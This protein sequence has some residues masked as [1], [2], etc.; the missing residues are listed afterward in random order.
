MGTGRR[1]IVFSNLRDQR[2]GLHA[3]Q[4][5]AVGGVIV[6]EVQH[7]RMLLMP[8]Q[9]NEDSGPL[10]VKHVHLGCAQDVGLEHFELPLNPRQSKHASEPAAT[11]VF[12]MQTSSRDAAQEI[13]QKH[14][15]AVET[16]KICEDILAERIQHLLADGHGAH[17]AVASVLAGKMESS[18][19]TAPLHSQA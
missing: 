1:V 13:F 14:E 3:F 7:T 12:R 6:R 4:Q 5:P 2:H 16:R 15:S 17:D 19:S 18:A 11:T 10:T 9:Q 8:L